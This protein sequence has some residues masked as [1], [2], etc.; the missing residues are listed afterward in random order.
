MLSM[1]T[2]H[3]F[4]AGNGC[5]EI[6]GVCGKDETTADL[7]D[8]MIYGLQ[9][10]AQYAKRLR[11]AGEK[12]TKADEF[13]LYALFTTLTNVNF[14]ANRFRTINQG[15]STMA[16]SAKAPNTLQSIRPAYATLE[17]LSGPAHWRPASNMAGLLTQAKQAAINLELQ[18]IGRRHHRFT[19]H[20]AIRH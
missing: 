17:A 8:L 14:N 18:A 10:I 3:P 16:G 19:G 13:I 4:S 5:H 11:Q 12:Q 6:K 9:G 1:R 2:N 20:V 7:Q 15:D